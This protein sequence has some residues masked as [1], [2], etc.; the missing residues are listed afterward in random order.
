MPKRYTVGEANALIP[1][2][3]KLLVQARGEIGELHG[4]LREANGELLDREW[5][6]RQARLEGC[7]HLETLQG[8]WDEAARELENA[9]AVL[10]DRQSHWLSQL[11]AMAIELRDLQRGLVDFPAVGPDGSD[12]YLCWH[13]GE[14]EIG[15]WHDADCGFQDRKPIRLLPERF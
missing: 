14:E 12:V 13:L 1:Y 8:A 3:S 2:L 9:K 11:V 6:L 4:D 15:F 5:A 7:C 10:S